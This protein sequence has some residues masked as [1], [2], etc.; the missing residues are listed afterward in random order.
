MSSN[1]GLWKVFV[2]NPAYGV[3]PIPCVSED[4]IQLDDWSEVLG[5]PLLTASD[6]HIWQ[7]APMHEKS[8]YVDFDPD[9]SGFPHLDGADTQSA[10]FNLGPEDLDAPA[11]RALLLSRV[12]QPVRQLTWPDQSKVRH[13]IG[14]SPKI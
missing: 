4:E 8:L 3:V 11:V 2:R 9:K 14:L 1:K 5:P 12:K 6:F 10:W 7:G 13:G